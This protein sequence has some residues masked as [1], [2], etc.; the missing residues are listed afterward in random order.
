MA[1][2]AIVK[3]ILAD[4]L[5]SIRTWAPETPGALMIAMSAAP[6]AKRTG[7]IDPPLGCELG[8]RL[9]NLNRAL[10]PSFDDFWQHIIVASEFVLIH[11]LVL[12]A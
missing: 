4:T 11:W 3:A 10:A 5:R 7:I 6:A 9:S 12:F 1:V 2:S 8:L